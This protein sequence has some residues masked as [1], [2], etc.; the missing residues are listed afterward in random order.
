MT[1]RFILFCEPCGHKEV[2]KDVDGCDFTE[3][4]RSSVQTNIPK[5]DTKSNKTVASKT[6]R[7]AKM[8]KCP[9]CGR[10]VVVKPIP[11]SYTHVIEKREKEELDQRKKEELVQDGW[12]PSPFEEEA[13][14]AIEEAKKY[15][16]SKKNK[17]S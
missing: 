6:N 2:I 15:G 14:K 12:I 1:K 7:Q 8:F 16:S 5:L 3:V 4:P 10:G 11:A 17:S 9:C 13:K